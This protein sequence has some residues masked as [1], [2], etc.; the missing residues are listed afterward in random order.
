MTDT[1]IR[2]P[3][4]APWG[5]DVVPEGKA[6]FTWRDRVM[7]EIRIEIQELCTYGD[8]VLGPEVYQQAE[9]DLC[10]EDPARWIALWL[11]IEEPRMLRNERPVKEYVP[12][13]FQVELAQ[14]FA[15]QTAKPEPFDGYISK[16]R[17]LGASWIFSAM[18]MWAWLFK[19]W[20]GILI[21]RKEDLV[22]KKGDLNSLFGKIDF[23]IEHLPEWFLPVSHDQ[24]FTRFRMKNFLEHPHT[25]AALIGEATTAKSTRGG[26]ATFIIYDEAAFIP[27]FMTVF[28][29]GSGTTNHRWAVSSESF[30]EGSD[31]WDMWH[32]AQDRDPN[33]VRELHWRLNPYF[34]D[35]WYAEEMAR[36]EHDPNGFQREYERNPFSDD[37]W[38]YPT[39]RFIKTFDEPLYPEAEFPHHDPEE[40]LLVG[41]DP[42]RADDTAIVFMQFSGDDEPRHVRWVDSYSRNLMPAEYYAHILT[43]I[44]PRPGD[45]CYGLQFDTYA[46]QRIMPWMRSLPWSGSMR[47][48]CD[49]SGAAKDM[50]G[51]SFTDRL[52]I[53]SKR[54]RANSGLASERRLVGIVPLYEELFAANRHDKRRLELRKML[55]RSS[56]CNTPGAKKLKYALEQYRFSDPGRK[57]TSQPAPLHDAYSHLS[58][59]AEYV[60]V[61]CSVG[62]G[63]IKPAR[64]RK[65]QR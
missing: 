38:I 53:E 34:D 1:P 2:I 13:A 19:P 44:E 47:V 43:G 30:E 40:V 39:V 24:I 8:G 23:I 48:F 5:L 20:R 63:R 14:W 4:F 59:A 33:A 32:A 51:K 9:W 64:E 3:S 45:T 29:T 55:I 22:D 6:W 12:F 18:A 37:T 15:E 31:W 41:I 27:D 11:W 42:G 46:T 62:L 26:R 21:S 16:A 17:G 36:W 10:A 49:P 35:F 28:G 60:A 7:S 57:S 54:L 50:S 52:L 61:Y 25:T 58:T 65:K 56:F